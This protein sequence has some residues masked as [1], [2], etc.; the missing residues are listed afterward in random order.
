MPARVV[1]WN[2]HGGFHHKH[3]DLLK[4]DPD[5]AV[6]S[7]TNEKS[8]T[9][10]KD[11]STAW[12]GSKH[13]GLAVV[14]RKGWTVTD[15]RLR[16]GETYFLPVTL[17]RGEERLKILAAWVVP[18]KKGGSYVPPTLSAIEKLKDFLSAEDVMLLGDLNQNVNFDGRR[19]E[20]RRFQT[21][22]D[23]LGQ[24]G[25]ASLWHHHTGCGH[26]VEDA[27]T[28]YHHFV[29]EQAFHIDYAFAARAL[30]KRARNVAVG[31]YAD[32]VGK[33]LSD[34]VPVIVDLR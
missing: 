13:K 5:I 10:I 2:C 17:Q 11:A 22:L 3:D 18:E 29:R 4:L 28:Y 34:H 6:V 8:L 14:G 12:I 25:L 21:V 7:E 9:H 19:G 1:A 15:T 23:Q 30:Q 27:P 24:L 33:R 26:G 20:A 31:T 32:W 16:I